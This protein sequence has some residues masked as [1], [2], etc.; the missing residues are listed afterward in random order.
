MNGGEKTGEEIN[1]NEM[2]AAKRTAAKGSR[3]NELD[4]R[5][6]I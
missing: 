4:P 2:M 3:R 6:G 1:G 5:T